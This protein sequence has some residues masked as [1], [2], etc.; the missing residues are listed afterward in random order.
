MNILDTLVSYSNRFGV[1]ENLVLAGGGNTSAKEGNLMYVKGS[2]VSLAEIAAQDFVRMDLAKLQ[3]VF[4]TAYPA[5]DAAREAVVLADLMD[6]REAGQENKRP[7]VETPL[8][9]LF[10]QT[11]V[12]H[13]HP[14]LVNGLT[15]GKGGETCARQTLQRDFI[16]VET[17]K[18]GYV[19]SSLC[20]ERM[21]EYQAANGRAAD[22][23]VLQNHGIFFAANSEAELES[24]LEAVL[25]D[26]TAA[27]VRQPAPQ[28]DAALTDTQESAKQALLAAYG[29]PAQALFCGNA[30][31]LGFCE[32]PAALLEPFTP[33]HIVYCKAHPLYAQDLA[34]VPALLAEYMAKHGYRP[35]V[36]L[37]K[38]IG[39]FCFGGNEKQ[40]ATCRALF[41][42]AVKV[43]VY[44]ESFGGP[45]HMSR[46]LTD[47]IVNWEVE[48][49]R[50]ALNK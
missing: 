15:C 16:W 35:R 47:F 4:T 25:A 48:S 6:A 38:G 2:G 30:D 9:A 27:L 10:P 40:A 36:F 42:D 33:D 26:L 39:A 49:Y 20:A 37:L 11:F 12:L 29:E 41:A 45:L 34:S 18:P 28:M 13:I 3:K 44:S 43:A 32:N 24:M 50:V 19:L 7:S 21:A 22:M 23:I 17:C 31:V 14:A 46:D 8:H 1:D 5:D